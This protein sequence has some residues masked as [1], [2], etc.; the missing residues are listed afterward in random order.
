MAELIAP[1]VRLHSSWLTARDEW[2]PGAHQDG[3]GLRLIADDDL[4]SPEDFASW[5]ERLRQQSDRSLPV[6]PGRVHATHWWIVDGETYLGAIDL[7]HYLNVFL[8]EADGYI[9][10]SILSSDRRRALAS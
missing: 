8:L 10:Y 4:N 7:R 2:Q 6:G 5:V 1:T 3:A 9:G